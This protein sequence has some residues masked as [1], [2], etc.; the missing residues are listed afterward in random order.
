MRVCDVCSDEDNERLNAD[1]EDQYRHGLEMKLSGCARRH[2]GLGFSEPEPPPLPASETAS[3]AGT[4]VVDGD[5][6]LGGVPA[7]KGRVEDD[8]KCGDGQ[9]A[10]S[11][12]GAGLEGSLD[13]DGKSEDVRMS[14]ALTGFIHGSKT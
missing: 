2:A 14:T 13:A 4:D 7:E 3:E 5:G 10:E 1:L 6:D 12:C 8:G 9:E 11:E